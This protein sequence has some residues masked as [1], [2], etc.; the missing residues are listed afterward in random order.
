MAKVTL[1]DLSVE[2]VDSIERAVGIPV[3]RWSEDAPKAD[4]Y[5]RIMAAANG[6][7]VA[8]YRSMKLREL[9]ALVS[10]DEDEADPTTP[11]EP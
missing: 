7:D 9:L 8:R 11:N 4:L 1:M 5:A 3:N 10:L 6:D 2:D